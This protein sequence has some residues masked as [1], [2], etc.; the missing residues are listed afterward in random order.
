MSRKERMKAPPALPHM[1]ITFLG[2]SMAAMVVLVVASW[3]F[4]LLQDRVQPHPFFST[5]TLTRA[6]GFLRELLGI[7]ASGTPAFARWEEWR[8]A[9]GLAYDTLIM[10]VLA[11]GL[12]GLAAL[13]TFMF[14]ARNVRLDE[15]AP[16]GHWAWR[17]VFFLVRGLYILTRGVPELVWAMLIIFVLAPGVLPG[18]IALAIHNWGVL[19]KLSAEVVEG[20]DPRPMRALRS[21]GAGRFQML[22]YG[23]LPQALPRFLTYLFYRWEIIIRTTIIVGF[24]AAGG[25]GTEFRLSMSH[26]HYTTVTLL[27]MWYLLLVLGVDLAAGALRRLAR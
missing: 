25:L 26:F 17:A 23:V 11:I 24:V 21:A 3:A 1:R 5:E 18:A 10:S 14:G 19:G 15:L 7:G 4:V 12:A 22:A 8:T 13:A 20:L 2:A 9:A 6:W 27:L 16:Y